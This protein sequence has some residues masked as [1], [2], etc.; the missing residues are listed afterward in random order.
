[1]YDETNTVL[2]FDAIFDTSISLAPV[3]LTAMQRVL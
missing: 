1:L 2:M 3:F